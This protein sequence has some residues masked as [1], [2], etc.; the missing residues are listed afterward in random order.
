MAHMLVLLQHILAQLDGVIRVRHAC[1]QVPNFLLATPMLGIS[2]WGCYSFVVEHGVQSSLAALLTPGKSPPTRCPP[3]REDKL[4]RNR[5]VMN[6]NAYSNNDIQNHGYSLGNSEPCYCG[7]LCNTRLVLYIFIMQTAVFIC[8]Q[9]S[10][11]AKAAAHNLS[12]G[13][14]CVHCTLGILGS[15]C[16]GGHARASGYAAA[17]DMPAV[18][19]VRS[20]AVLP[21]KALCATDLAVFHGICSIGLCVVPTILTLDMKTQCATKHRPVIAQGMRNLLALHHSYELIDTSSVSKINV[22]PPGMIPPA[23]RSPAGHKNVGLIHR[24]RTTMP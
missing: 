18:V 8:R 7:E 3:A 16:D 14:S 4:C 11:D 15:L 22:A 2:F 13:G 10:A 19:L 20:T 6:N 9:A 21:A 23:P 24:I 12:F 1:A 5:A 17:V